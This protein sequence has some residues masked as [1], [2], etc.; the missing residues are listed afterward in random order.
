[1]ERIREDL[2]ADWLDA[3]RRRQ[4]SKAR[5]IEHRIEAAEGVVRR[6]RQPGRGD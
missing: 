4:P 1:M 2:Y 3:V 5:S 6:R